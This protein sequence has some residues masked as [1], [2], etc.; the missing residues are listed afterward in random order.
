[1]RSDFQESV[2]FEQQSLGNPAVQS[3]VEAQKFHEITQEYQN[4]IKELQLKLQKQPETKHE[5]MNGTFNS[6]MDGTLN[7]TVNDRGSGRSNDQFNDTQQQSSSS[8]QNLQFLYQRI[9]QLT[10]GLYCQIVIYN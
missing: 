10:Q 2:Q 7:G 9:D 4:T 3:V 8:S 6:P 1:M 5:L